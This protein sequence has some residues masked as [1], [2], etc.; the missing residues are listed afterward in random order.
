[1]ESAE[2]QVTFLDTPGHEAFTAMRARGAKVTDIAVLVVAADDG[3]M[4]QTI[5]AISLA[6][7][8]GR[9]DHRRSQQNRQGLANLNQ[10]K[11]QMEAAQTIAPEDW[12]GDTIIVPVAASTGAGNRELLETILLQ[13]EVLE[14]KR[15]RRR[16]TNG[17]GDRIGNREGPRAVATVLVKRGTLRLGAIRSSPVRSSGGC[18]RCSM[19]RVILWSRRRLRCRSWCW[20]SPARRTRAKSARDGRQ[21]PEAR[22]VALYRQGKFRDVKLARQSTR[23]EDAFS[24]MGEEKAGVVPV[25]LK[26]GTCRAAPRRVARRAQQAVH[27]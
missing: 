16:Q 6:K 9:A 5:E 14:L 26:T 17:S 20:D 2:G 1:M 7:R 4:P 11:N 8:S 10:V 21:A 18:A 3:L 13:A 24:Q 12:G 25:L 22:E 19:R 23:A 15:A 27:G